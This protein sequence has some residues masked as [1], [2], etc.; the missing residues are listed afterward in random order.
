MKSKNIKCLYKPSK[1]IK[2]VLFIGY[3]KS[4][5]SVINELIK[6]GCYLDYTNKPIEEC[7]N[8]D[9]IVSFGYRYILKKELI[10]KIKCPIFNLH[11]SYLPYNRGSHPNFWSFYD[12]TPSGVTIHLIDDGID[13]GPIIYQKK[14]NFNKY[15][16]T[17]EQTYYKLRFELENLFIKNIN[18]II[19]GTWT[20]KPQKKIG[21]YHN[22]KDLPKNFS[23]W[24]SNVNHEINK[25]YKE[26]LLYD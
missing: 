19:K 11:I 6:H 2:R 12:K 5:T 24:S 4:E 3:Q 17:F 21:T 26:G 15:K 1:P 22:F 14:L 18:N 7:G 16:T 9:F 25:L 10:E 23:G 8:Y 13:T 20:A